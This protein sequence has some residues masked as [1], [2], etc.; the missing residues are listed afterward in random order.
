MD[1][2]SLL[3]NRVSRSKLGLPAPTSVELDTL[4]QAAVRAPDHGA[5]KPWRF[6]VIEGERLA[7]LSSVFT[8]SAQ[9]AGESSAGVLEKIKNMPFRAPMIIIP[10]SKCIPNHKVPVV[11]QQLSGAAAVQNILLGLHAL[12]YGGIWRTGELAYNRQVCAQ[13][14]LTEHESL[15]GFLYTGTPVGDAPTVSALNPRDFYQ[16]W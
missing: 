14:G 9:V 3:L 8:S 6:L 4:I 1:A 12:G 11:E 10:V 15:L 13:L 16:Y 7:A 5:L 2:I